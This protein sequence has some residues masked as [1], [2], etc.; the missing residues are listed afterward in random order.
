MDRFVE[1]L[2]NFRKSTNKLDIN[3]I[4]QLRRKQKQNDIKTTVSTVAKNST[5]IWCKLLD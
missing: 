3:E 5:H 4:Y 1:V 2:L